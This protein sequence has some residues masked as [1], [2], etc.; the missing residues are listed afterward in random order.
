MEADKC[1]EKVTN[2]KGCHEESKTNSMLHSG[3]IEPYEWLKMFR[4]SLC[5]SS[6]ACD[7]AN[8]PSMWHLTLAMAGCWS[9]AWL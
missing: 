2:L 5:P 3:F 8:G 6:G 7:Y 4:T 9:G 1:I